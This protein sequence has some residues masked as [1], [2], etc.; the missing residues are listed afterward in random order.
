MRSTDLRRFTLAVLAAAIFATTGCRDDAGDGGTLINDAGDD[1]TAADVSDAGGGDGG[2]PDGAAGGDGGSDAAD[3]T[4]GGDGGP[5]DTQGT[6]GDA[7]DPGDTQETDGDATDPGDTSAG[8]TGLSDADPGDADPGD[9]HLSDADPGDTATPADTADPGDTSTPADTTDAGGDTTEP[10]VGEVVDCENP[11]LVPVPAGQTCAATTGSDVILL[12]GRI[13]GP[14]K[15][16][17]SGQVLIQDGAIQC[18]GCDCDVWP[19]AKSATLVHCPNGVVSP[20]LI[21]AHDHIT[22]TMSPPVGHGDERYEHRHDWRKGQNGHTK[23]SVSQNS[24]S[25]GESWGELR[26]LL[27]GVTSINSSG[28][29]EGFLRNLD[30]SYLLEGLPGKKGATYD[31]FPLGDSS[32]YTAAAGCGGYSIDPATS[33]AGDQAYCPHVAEGINEFAHNEFLC[34]SGTG[35]GSQNYL[36]SNV[37]FIHSIG[38]TATDIG[39]MALQSTSLIWSPRSNIDLY[40]HTAA[41][42]IYR[43]LGV[44]IALGTDWSASGSMNM[45]RELQ[46]ADSLN[47]DL[48]GGAFSD[49]ELVQMATI[50]GAVV[51]GVDDVLGSL[52][53]GKVADIAVFRAAP[54]A[55]WRGVLDA[56]VQDTALVLR[57]GLVQLGDADLVGKLPK[58]GPSD[59]E[60]LDVCGVPKKVCTPR[61]IG[62]TLAQLQSAIMASYSKTYPLFFCGAPQNEPSC[63][64]FRK[65]E[66]DGKPKAGDMDGDGIADAADN[67][68]DVFNPPR[69]MDKG[70]Q[71]D[72][73]GDK[74][75][76]A[77]DPCPFDANS[78]ACTSVDPNDVDSDGVPNATD[79]CKSAAN[80]DQKDADQDGK[81]DACDPCP[82]FPNP[83]ASGCPTSIYAIKKG[84]AGP[85]D[86]VI[87]QDAVV[88]AVGTQGFVMQARPDTGAWEG[89]KFSGLYVYTKGAIAV[90]QGDRVDV[91]GAV[92]DYYG[93]LQLINASVKVLPGKGVLPDPAD[94]ANP[95]LLATTSEEADAW[96]SVLVRVGPVTVTSVA[97]DPAG[98]KGDINEFVVTGELRVDDFFHLI[99]PFPTVGETFEGLTGVMRWSFKN[100]KLEPRDALDVQK[101]PPALLGFAPPLVAIKAGTAGTTTP[102]LTVKLTGPAKA[103]TDIAITSANP[104]AVSVPGGKVTIPAGASSVEVPIVAAVAGAPVTLTATLGLNQA[105]AQVKVYAPGEVPAVTS[106]TP[107]AATTLLGQVASFTVGL[108]WPAPPGGAVVDL[109][110]DP[111]GAASAPDQI[112]IPAGEL[113]ASFDV[114]GVAAGVVGLS[115]T[116][117]GSTK[118]ATLEVVETPPLGLILMEVYYDHPSDDVGFEWVKLYNGT[119]TTVDLSGWSI[120][121]GGSDYLYKTVQLQGSVPP[122][123]CFIVGGPSSVDANGSPVYGQSVSFGG[124]I[125]NGGPAA[126]GLAL[127]DVKASALAKTTVPRDAVLWGAPGSNSSNLLGP[128]GLPSVVHVKDV[129]AGQSVVRTGAGT[130]DVSTKPNTV[131]CGPPTE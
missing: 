80:P 44:V 42:T 6:D 47:S 82:A 68:P 92:S 112:V 126:D 104:G 58:G 52:A 13:L 127:F 33:I 121:T 43:A 131:P 10:P 48:Y 22:F 23:L 94:V 3:T 85:G 105:T 62:M 90:A 72:A 77:C 128:D 28:G 2:V 101:G 96:E 40:G 56:E 79:N 122:G 38:V 60:P 4:G 15:V 76:D 11:P 20:G 8:D 74:Q 70:K 59:C 5:G 61:E 118:A 129:S 27:S 45:L 36:M 31:T 107:A 9:A 41:V 89:P 51:L 71:P 115:A 78:T 30:K 37:A 100:M 54:G 108:A 67:C 120:G 39:L 57:G 97:P 83:G 1:G 53:P 93:Q 32:G 111:P 119:T 86:S 66:F 35:S 46:C 14:S 123:A 63:T 75:G 95:A 117:G 69:P 88:T 110:L 113:S 65:G 18:V 19:E 21:N 125:Q 64:P 102:P 99:T 16:L 73:D 103:P 25:K 50:N 106:L 116:G 87:V 109:E 7:A 124:N 34:L 29:E 84:V 55:T 130:W 114:L 26:M 98:E 91:T 49:Q 24:Y 12:Q 17:L 81:G